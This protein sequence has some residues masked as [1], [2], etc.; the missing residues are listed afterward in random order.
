MRV[1]SLRY[2]SLKLFTIIGF[3]GDKSIEQ[4]AYGLERSLFV[5]TGLTPFKWRPFGLKLKF[6]STW[7]SWKAEI[8][9]FRWL[10]FL[11]VF[12]Q[13]DLKASGLAKQLK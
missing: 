7:S 8:L 2:A 12:K 11:F 10:S 4:T 5:H 6:A 3:S 13:T 9:E 1:Y